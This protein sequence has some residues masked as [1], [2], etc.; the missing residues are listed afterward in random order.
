M[1]QA[2]QDELEPE[3]AAAEADS[4]TAATEAATE[5]TGPDEVIADL[6]QQVRDLKDKWLRQVAENDNQKKRNK[7]EIDDAVLRNS[8]RLLGD[9]LPT[10]DNLSRALDTAKTQTDIAKGIEMVLDQFL[11]ALTKHG[12]E[13]V[14]G[15]G[16]AFDP[17]FHEALQQ[18]PSTEYAPGTVCVVYEQGFRRGD[19]LLRAARVVIASPESTGG[20][21]N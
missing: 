19:K 8:Q 12:I 9:F 4:A 21:A 10:V 11:K 15:V 18:I 16:H 14:P 13:P 1:T 3:T 17:A 5:A 7:R 20:E 2:S 6:E